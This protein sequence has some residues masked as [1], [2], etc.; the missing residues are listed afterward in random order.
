MGMK[1][2]C[3]WYN[4]TSGMKRAFDNGML[5]KKWIEDYCWNDGKGCI[6]KKRFEEEG[7]VSPD[8]V[9]PDGSVSEKLKKWVE[10]KNYDM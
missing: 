6:R 9:L 1:Q 5:D 4:E 3:K 2:L 7:Y 10:G 8:Y